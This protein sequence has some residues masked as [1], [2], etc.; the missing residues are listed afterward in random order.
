MR[1]RNL[2]QRIHIVNLYL[3]FAGRKQVEQLVNIVFEFFPSLNVA[4]QGWPCDFD[5]LGA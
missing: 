3:Q 2:I 4:K 1:L 5:T